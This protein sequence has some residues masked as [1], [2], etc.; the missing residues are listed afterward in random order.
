M[1]TWRKECAG[2]WRQVTV[3]RETKGDREGAKRAARAAAILE[4][5]DE[6]RVVRR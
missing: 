1:T 5:T 2:I 3:L 4:T 6:A